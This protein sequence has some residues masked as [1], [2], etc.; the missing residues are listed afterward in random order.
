MNLHKTVLTL[1]AVAACA[2]TGTAS[3]GLTGDT[4]GARYLGSAGEDSG[5]QYSVVGAGEEGNFFTNQFYD[6]S[7]TGFA[8][9]SISNFCG[10]FSCS[11]TTISLIL[12][13]LDMG[14]PITDVDFSTN[15]SGVTR[16]FTSD[17]ATFT[18]DEQALTTGTYLTARFVTGAAVPEP[19]SLALVSVALAGAGL[20]TQLRRKA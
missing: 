11:G 17:S 5:V 4:V 19:L 7:D 20:A 8:I 6:F 14:S 3:A 9:R 16:V 2:F 13:S 1:A 10:I 12:S 15:L 18:W